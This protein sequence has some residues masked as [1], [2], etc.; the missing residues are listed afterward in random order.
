MSTTSNIQ[1]P[2]AGASVWTSDGK[3]FGYVKEVRGDY[4]K[5]DIPWAADYWLACAHIAEVDGPRTILRLRHDE[6]D[7]HRLEQ[8]G[9]DA[10]DERA[11]GV[12][13]A[14]EVANQ[15]E[16]MERELEMQKERMRAGLQ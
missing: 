15:R 14:E 6:L 12:F 4:F 9:L 8:P 5:V 16:R 7:G 3:Q 2:A 13:T 11:P 1:H 10:I